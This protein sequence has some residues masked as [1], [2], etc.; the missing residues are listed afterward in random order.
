MQR[1]VLL[2]RPLSWADGGAPHLAALLLE[3]L[4]LLPRPG[5]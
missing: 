1:T 5:G 4:P 3:P 2:G